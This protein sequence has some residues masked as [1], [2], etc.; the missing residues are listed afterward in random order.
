MIHLGKGE[1]E[2]FLAGRLNGAGRSRVVLHLLGG[3]SRCQREMK[4]LAAPIFGEEPW[5]AAPPVVE[6]RYDE[7]FAR[8]AGTARSFAGRWRKEREKLERALSLLDQFPSGLEDESFPARQ[9]QSLHGWP[10][11]EALL[12][13]S[14]EVRFSDPKRM[15]DLA[16]SAASVAKHI[17]SEKYP[18]PGFL[19]DVRARAF[20]ELGNAYRV[21]DR[22][23]EA[24]AAFGKAREHLESGTA[25][26]LLHA[27]VLDLEAS[28]RR[29]QRRLEDA[30]VLLDQVHNLYL[31][32]GDP[33]L[34]GRALISKGICTH[35]QGHPREAVK[36][37]EEG[38]DLLAPG[39]DPQLESSTD[40]SII[41][42][43]V[44]CGG[45]HQA[46]RL[47]LQSGLR[48][49]FAAEPLILL[50]LRGV[51]G[52]IHA[53]LGRLARAERVFGEVRQEFLRHGQVYDAALTGLELATVWLRQ[54]RAAQVLELAEEMHAVFEDL[55][56]QREAA[57]ALDFVREACHCQ[58]V[59]VSMIER[60]RTF[61]ERLPWHPGLR[62]EPA[63]F[64][65]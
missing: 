46:S 57:R 42:A 53:G 54:G 5:T 18:W 17:R 55:G 29:A 13:K 43:L 15:L 19:S 6:E 60:V 51:E 20:A 65:P 39:R 63:L 30:A 3:C 40:L 56:V 59:T 50:K 10:L 61:L 41:Y 36:L 9:A 58:I 47:I 37:L 8:A 12:R 2:D 16:E 7:A 22:L 4:A 64:A 32:A 21:N 35:Y 45:Y 27:R 38:L 62:F 24:D 44:D 28:L 1:I 14:S 25:D 23:S 49:A 11:C 48:K 52:K 33:H 31:E 26:P 34:A